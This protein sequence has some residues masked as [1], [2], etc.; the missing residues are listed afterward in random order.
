M[1]Q[2]VLRAGWL[3]VT[4]MTVSQLGW[5]GEI[6]LTN[7]YD[8]FGKPVEG[9]TQDFGFSMVVEYRGKTILFDSGTDASIF[10]SNLE[11]LG[12]DPREID[13]AIASHNHHDH[14][15]GFDY[16][17]EV[18]PDVKL[19]LPQ[20]F[21]LG[22]TIPLSVAGTDPAAAESLP[23]EMRYFGGEADKAI[24]ASSG[25]FWKADAEYVKETKVIDEGV[26]LIATKSDLMGV[27]MRY[28]PF[29]EEPR[30]VPM[31]ELSVSF[32]TSEGEVVLVGCSH[33]SVEVIARATRDQ[34]GHDIRLLVGGYHLLPY[35]REYIA[36]LAR[37]LRE[38]VG[39]KRV[40]PAHCSGH[41]AFELFRTEFGDD[42]VLF[43]LG[44]SLDL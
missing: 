1:R 33:S 39:V 23:E 16:L 20:D 44:S 25:R 2:V 18:N 19:Y 40:A 38:E 30:L 22:A 10:K 32:A 28:P 11:G 8:A 42:Y 27:F 17:L 9:V 29:E 24:I 5:A 26:T 34:L 43:G 31:P 6:K 12:I 13:I 36:A 35:D 15:A 37:R 3:L 7:V 4:V 21:T 14:I 41:L